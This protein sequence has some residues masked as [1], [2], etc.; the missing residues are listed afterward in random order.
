MIQASIYRRGHELPEVITCRYSDHPDPRR[1]LEEADPLEL[2]LQALV[3][4]LHIV[5]N[6]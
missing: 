1:L 5:P 3:K 4:W 2:E 6:S